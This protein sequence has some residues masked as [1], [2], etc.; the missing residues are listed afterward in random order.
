MAGLDFYN[1]DHL[2]NVI[3]YEHFTPIMHEDP[4][5][6][7]PY[8]HLTY[9]KPKISH[10]LYDSLS[11]LSA[12]NVTYV[13]KY[14][15]WFGG[16]VILL[17]THVTPVGIAK[18]NLCFNGTTICLNMIVVDNVVDFVLLGCDFTVA[19]NKWLRHN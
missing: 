16:D 17:H 14:D 2:E 19:Y 8:E 1:D 7:I 13:A 3:P 15:K 18:V 6:V 12:I 9:A 10:I 5:N 4:T 11:Y